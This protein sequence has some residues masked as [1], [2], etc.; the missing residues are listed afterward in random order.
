[1]YRTS[2]GDTPMV[3]RWK[4]GLLFH[5]LANDLKLHVVF[6]ITKLPEGYLM[7]CLN[8]LVLDIPNSSTDPHAKVSRK[9]FHQSVS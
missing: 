2:C 4:V 9:S 8:G 6:S 1:M 3:S 7:S 5:I